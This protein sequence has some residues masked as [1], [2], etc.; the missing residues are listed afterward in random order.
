M[1]SIV[2]NFEYDIFISYRH[3][4]NRSG[5]VTEFVNALQEELAS[6]IKE[7][8]TIYFD[9][10]PQ[11]GLLETHNVDKSLEGKLKCLIFIPIISQTYCDT[12]SFA[13]QH[14]F[15]AFNKLAQEDQFGRDIKLSNGNVASRILPIKIHDLDA[16]DKAAIETEIAG[17]LRA[18]EFI[19]KE[20]GVNRPLKSTDNRNDNQNKTE[21]RNQVNKVANSIK[22]IITALK[23]PK[24]QNPR[25][26]T[27]NQPSTKPSRNRKPVLISI[28]ILLTILAGYF[29][30]QQRSTNPD[31][32][33]TLD[34]SIAVLPFV[35]ITSDQEQEYFSDGLTEDIITQLAKIRS[36]KVISRT[37]VM[38]YKKN[39]KS[40]KVIGKELNVSVIL[41]G[42]VQRSGDQVR[43]TAQ[44]IKAETDEHLWAESYDRPMKDILMIQREVATA[45]ASVLRA[46]LSES[47]SIQ[48]N[49]AITDN[50]QAYNL[51]LKGKFE[52]DKASRTSLLNAIN[53]YSQA[54]Q[55]DSGF[56]KAYSSLANT[57]L[58]QSGYGTEDPA[59]VLPLAR[60]YIDKA[61]QLDPNSAEVY[62]SLGGWYRNSFN[63]KQSERMLRK[64]LQINPE[65]EMAIGWLANLL[66][67]TGRYKEALQTLKKNYER[68]PGI[69]I[70]SLL[71]TAY[72]RLNMTINPEDAINATKRRIEAASIDPE[73]QKNIYRT[74]ARYYWYLGRRE[75][76]ISSAEHAEDRGLV[77]YYKEGNNDWLV[78]E[79]KASQK[80][81]INRGYYFSPVQLVFGYAEA[82]AHDKALAS[83]EIAFEKRDPRLV[84]LLMRSNVMFFPESISGYN[85]MRR[86][87]R[88]II[89]YD[90]PPEMKN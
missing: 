75:E 49:E 4:D 44:L 62:A 53:Y 46:T 28:A 9:K 16:E 52:Q 71:V 63:F 73:R 13:W 27:N 5:W 37:S 6:T 61:I 87:I 31:T 78:E 47:E 66:E 58:D 60:K 42:S 74:L 8:L 7:P 25:T 65:Q 14:E 50:P 59:K 21:F 55:L 84:L 45:I 33:P 22:D 34:K 89:N 35:N 36:F 43:I 20:P 10:N 18:I 68:I 82:G 79:V 40:L 54:I 29:F 41:E 56:T 15:V 23:K 70:Y 86:K 3:N 39:P 11:D 85:E 88:T 77:R 48:L 67:M 83:F 19:Y 64:S 51:Y 1:P 72:N 26:T 12:K 32:I 76:A 17:V 81:R 38:Q 69:D 30:Y 24:A 90:W 57:Y 2:P 80:D